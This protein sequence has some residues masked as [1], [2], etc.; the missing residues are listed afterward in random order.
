M[1]RL[2]E[3]AAAQV[4]LIHTLDAVLQEGGQAVVTASAPPAE[5][6]GLMPGLQSR[7]VAGLVLPLSPPGA[8]ARLAILRQLARLRDIALS[9][10]A[11]QLLADGL[12]GTTPELLG[13]LLQLHVPASEEGK[14]IDAAAVRGYLASRNGRESRES[15]R[16][17]R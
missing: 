15:R 6:K 1:G 11:A 14:P 12:V 10:S 2:A 5:L 9:D 16:S 17:P 8:G 7:L 13:A 4:E 3:K